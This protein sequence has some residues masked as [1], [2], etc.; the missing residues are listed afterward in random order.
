MSAEHIPAVFV[1]ALLSPNQYD[2]FSEL[3]TEAIDVLDEH[4]HPMSGSTATRDD[5]VVFDRQCL[6]MAVSWSTVPAGDVLVLSVGARPEHPFP[7]KGARFCAEV[8][9]KVLQRA[10]AL[11]E[12]QRTLWQVVMRPLNNETIDA[13][14]YQLEAMDF[15]T[16]NSDRQYQTD[17]Q[18]VRVF[19]DPAQKDEDELNSMV[20]DLSSKSDEGEQE[21]ERNWALQASA[22]ALSTTFVLVTPPVGLAMFAYAALRQST[23]MDLLPRNLDFSNTD[24]GRMVTDMARQ[25]EVAAAR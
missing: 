7:D 2:L 19:P 13:H 12:V 16:M 14:A 18:F 11:F 20:A 4:T 5:V 3:L 10:S 21:G 22:L 6:R 1:T 23:A 25:E 9:E 24:F 8:L 17:A 15:E